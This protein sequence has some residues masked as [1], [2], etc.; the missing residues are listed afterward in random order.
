VSGDD[1]TH[2]QKQHLNNFFSNLVG[3]PSLETNYGQAVSYG[4]RRRQFD[5]YLLKR[6][7]ARVLP[8]VALTSLERTQDGWIAN[9][10]IQSRLV[11]GAGG[12]F[13]PVARLTGAKARG[14]TPVVAQET[15]FEMDAHRLANCDIR[16]DTPELY[17]CSDMKG[18]GWCF[19]KGNFLNIGLGRADSH[20][21][22]THVA[23]FSRFL[24]SAGR[25]SFEIPTFLG[26]AYLLH[27]YSR[28]EIVGD[29]FLLI[30]DSA[31]VAYPQSGEG[32]LPAIQSGLQAAKSIV[33]ANGRFTNEQLN[34]YRVMAAGRRQPW[35]IGLAHH[36]PQR[37]IGPIAQRLLRT[38]WFT[39]EVVLNGWFLHAS[40]SAL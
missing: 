3:G 25:I 17:F 23:E 6:S 4:I 26:H 34:A 21:L 35:A 36:L 28:R 14:E 19:R 40:S 12:H 20:R 32:I 10:E 13:C 30:G 15:E 37:L 11:I 31:G 1:Q 18:Y 33:A 38:H 7:G 8:P 27:G 24:V 22:S 39:R 9:G 16:G 2:R 5:D 29:G